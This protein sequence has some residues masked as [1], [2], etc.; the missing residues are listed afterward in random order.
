MELR[1]K[2]ADFRP[3]LCLMDWVLAIIK[4]GV[5]GRDTPGL[6]LIQISNSRTFAFSRP[7]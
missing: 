2:T 1:T 7:G 3:P 5:N 4:E 6:I